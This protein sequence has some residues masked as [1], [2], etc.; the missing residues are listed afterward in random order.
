MSV[1][2]QS[3]SIYVKLKKLSIDIREKPTTAS[4]RVIINNLELNR[5]YKVTKYTKGW[6][7]VSEFKGWVKV[8]DVMLSGSASGVIP[9]G[10]DDPTKDP[11]EDLDP[12]KIIE[13]INSA[14]GYID[15]YRISVVIDGVQYN[16]QS[17]LKLMNEKIKDLSNGGSFDDSEIRKE[18][19]EIYSIIGK[20]YNLD[21]AGVNN[22]IDAIN[23]INLKFVKEFIYDKD[24]R[25]LVII[26]ENGTKRNLNI[27]EIIDNI[28][29]GELLD[30]SITDIKDKQILIYDAKEGKFIP[31]DMGNV[32]TTKLLEEVKD[33][34]DEQ[35]GLIDLL[36]PEFVD[37]KPSLAD[38]E[39]GKWYLYEDENGEKVMTIYVD[40][41]EFNISSGSGV[42]VSDVKIDSITYTNEEVNN[43]LNFILGE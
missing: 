22:I 37:S 17:Y 31:G 32:D 27:G 6:Y 33:Y 20:I 35:I 9:G 30:V 39:N 29:I 42:G 23:I 40:G 18:I 21:I 12:E 41:E 8:V 19:E 1:A 28:S 15:A 34:V 38:A 43:F 11:I 2:T 14:T 5:E 16:L 10:D 3:V 4:N 24:N 13:L 25:K 7:Y 26:N 36:E